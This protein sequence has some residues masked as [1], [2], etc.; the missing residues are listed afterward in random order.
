LKNKEGGE[1]RLELFFGE[2]TND[3]EEVG[4]VATSGTRKGGRERGRDGGK[5][6]KSTK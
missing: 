4:D 1:G 3:G 5:I 6:R 2:A